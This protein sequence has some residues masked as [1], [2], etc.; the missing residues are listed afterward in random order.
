MNE[1]TKHSIYLY[2]LIFGEKPSVIDRATGAKYEIRIDNDDIDWMCFKYSR[3]IYI[4]FTVYKN[5]VGKER[6]FYVLNLS[7]KDNK[8][9]GV[10]CGTQCF[11]RYEYV[12]NDTPIE[13]DIVEW[14]ADH[15]YERSKWGGRMCNCA[16]CRAKNC[17]KQIKSAMEKVR[18]FGVE[19]FFDKLG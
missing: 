7:K 2:R 8:G 9:S 16:R 11:F 1:S 15:L 5:E 4:V 12:D 3:K 18:F 17:T 19:D 6:I 10:G 14:F 13:I